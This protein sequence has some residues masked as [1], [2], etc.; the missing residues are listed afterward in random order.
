VSAAELDFVTTERLLE[1][2]EFLDCRQIWSSNRVYIARLCSPQ[3]QPFAAIYK[4]QHGESPLWD[5]PSGTLY[6]REV[7]AYR[8]ARVLDWPFVP[9]TV[10]RDG[11]DGIGSL[12]VFIRHDP[13]SHYFEQREVAELVPQLQRIALFDYVANNADRKGGHCLLDEHRRVW[14]I[15][16]GLCFHAQYKLRTVIWDWSELPIAAEWLEQVSAAR[17][18]LAQA[19]D[20]DARALLELL[21]PG[22]AAALGQRM[23]A[24][25]RDG[26]FPKPGPHRPYPWPLI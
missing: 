20:D 26:V 9:P 24:I 14:G 16:H 7:A 11:P 22:E 23:D 3:G 12:Q 25:L 15:D 10:V 18:R 4:P 8:L 6:R 5:F 2:S 17:E 13:E 19:T 21:E 1:E